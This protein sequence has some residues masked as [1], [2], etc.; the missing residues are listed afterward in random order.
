M[1]VTNEH[2]LQAIRD[3]RKEIKAGRAEIKQ[4][5]EA[6]SHHTDRRIQS[7]IKVEQLESDVGQLQRDSH[8]HDTNGHAHA[9]SG[10]GDG[11]AG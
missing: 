9:T 3:C 4:F 10:D 5:A 6:L 2:L 1:T 8:R 11:D 7:D